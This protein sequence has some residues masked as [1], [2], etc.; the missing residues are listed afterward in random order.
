MSGHI[1]D[2]VKRNFP[3]D[4]NVVMRDPLLFGDFRNALKETEPR[5]YEDLLD[6]SA[7][8]HLFTEVRAWVRIPELAKLLVFRFI[9]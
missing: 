8:G 1:A 6:Y 4:V 5:Y 2:S 3:Q 9:Y 7:V